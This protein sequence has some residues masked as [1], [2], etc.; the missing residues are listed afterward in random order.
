MA[1]LSHATQ[2]TITLQPNVFGCN[3]SI[4]GHKKGTVAFTNTNNGYGHV[5]KSTIINLTLCV[6]YIIL[7]RVNSQREVQ[8]FYTI[9]YLFFTAFCLLY[10]FR[11]KLEVHNQ[12][13]C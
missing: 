11:K 12:V 8:F 4:T 1:V 7:L 3:M 9:N 6:P 10:M 2:I 13:H 5:G